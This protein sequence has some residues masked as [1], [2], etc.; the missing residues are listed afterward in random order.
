MK[1]AAL[2]AILTLL[3]PFR[4]WAQDAAAPGDAGGVTP[5]PAPA[6]VTPVMGGLIKPNIPMALEADQI[7][8]DDAHKTYHAHG[9]VKLR[10]GDNIVTADHMTYDAG[11]NLIVADGGVTF[12]TAQG[13]MKADAFEL[14]VD[15]QTA[16]MARASFIAR[17]PT[18]TYYLR[19]SRIEK[20]G[21]N[22]YLIDNGSYSTCDCGADEADWLVQAEYIDVT[23]DGYA[24]VERARVFLRGLPVAYLPI[25]VFPALVNRTTGF[26]SPT[27]GHVSYAGFVVDAPY[28][29]NISPHSDATFDPDYMSSRGTKLG[30]QYRYMI[31]KRSYGEFDGDAIQD[32]EY[33]NKT[34]WTANFT[35]QFNP[36]GQLYLRSQVNL[37]SDKDYV[38]DYP[39]DV[40][41]L[42]ARYLRSDMIANNLWQNYD[43]NVDA[44]HWIDLSVDDNSSTW[45]RYPDVQ[46]DSISQRIGPVPVY[47]NLHAAADNF[48]RIK[49]SPTD[50]AADLADGNSRPF[51]YLSQGQRVR[52]TPELHAPINFDQVAT[53]TPYVTGSGVFYNLAERENER[54]PAKLYDEAGAV[55]YTRFERVFPV[56]FLEMRGLKH[57][58]EPWVQYQYGKDPSRDPLPVFDPTDQPVG[59]AKATYGVTNRLWMKLFNP[60]DNSYG[61]FKLIDFRVYHGYDFHEADRRLDP[62][63]PNDHHRPW[64]P[65]QAELD[66]EG[67]LGGGYLDKFTVRSDAA[68]DEYSHT[69]SGF[70]ILGSLTSRRQDFVSL[71][72]RFHRNT[73][74]QPSINYFSNNS[75]N[76]YEP[77][78][79][80][81]FGAPD[82]NYITG[83]VHYTI[84]DFISVDYLTRY[85][86]I[87]SY[88]VESR[89]AIELHSFEKCFDV[90][91]AYDTR[92]LPHP[93]TSLQITFNLTGMIKATTTF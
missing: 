53:V 15:A 23:F 33:G 3:L 2:L 18:A 43:V 42:Y 32:A 60:T 54:N 88:F 38:N 40:P 11:R 8:F 28:Y 31:D 65:V 90:I 85:S 77:A 44:Q 91:I 61:T 36:V 70:D 52:L 1:R 50:I 83:N 20:V 69:M 13:E 73:Y 29:W 17:Q 87:N 64:M 63:N 26:L 71:E 39:H 59:V 76:A 67:A 62:T 93:A 4:V 89:Y 21:P 27:I 82:I 41:G 5:A 25:G 14:Q 10:Q 51:Y 47:W 9:A 74:G 57:Q 19:G 49:P 37:V 30:A 80:G 92:T 45:Q 78:A 56:D 72:Y 7:D 24:Y 6:T 75:V 35:E 81:A 16:V 68:Y 12:T 58:I 55:A 86:F 66:A 34:R 22:R 79:G 84:V 46:F 48:Y